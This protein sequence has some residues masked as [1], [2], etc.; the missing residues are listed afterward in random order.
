[1]RGWTGCGPPSPG[2]APVFPAHAGMDRHVSL[3]GMCPT[4]FSP[5]MRGW[6]GPVRP[7]RYRNSRFPRACGDGPAGDTVKIPYFNVF[8][9]HAGMDRIR[10]RLGR[11]STRFPRACGDG[12]KAQA[13]QRTFL[14]FSPRMRGWTDRPER[15]SSFQLSFPRACGDGP[16]SPT[17]RPQ[18]RQF[19]PRMRGWTAEP[20]CLDYELH[21]FP[22][23]AGMD[24]DQ[25]PFIIPARD[26][27]PAH[28]G[29]DRSR[30][31]PT[32]APPGVFPAHAG[33][34]REIALTK[35]VLDAFSPRMRG[36][37][38]MGNGA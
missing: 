11:G 3:Y 14:T 37:T 24:R 22:A 36:W 33:M 31:P 19:S 7:T 5:R 30:S 16:K 38:D 32:G 26:V 12:P 13:P 29:M 6:T 9:A 34:D 25:S 27:F 4:A 2:G 28:A 10:V 17:A 8:P 23:H 18:A 1:M 35:E 21:V 15:H 20:A